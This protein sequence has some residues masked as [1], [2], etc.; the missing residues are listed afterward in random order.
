[1]DDCVPLVVIAPEMIEGNRG[2]K[3]P[4]AE[5]WSLAFMCSI[6]DARFRLGRELGID[7]PTI[8]NG[9]SLGMFLEADI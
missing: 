6:F 9:E 3:L 8:E 7:I 2:F 1:M 4:R 5:T